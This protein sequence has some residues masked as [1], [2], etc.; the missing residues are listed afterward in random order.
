MNNQV[1]EPDNQESIIARWHCKE[2]REIVSDDRLFVRWRAA[3]T[4]R[5]QADL[6]ANGIFRI[7]SNDRNS[8][9]T[10]G[11][12]LVKPSS[13]LSWIAQSVR[14]ERDRTSDLWRMPLRCSHRSH[15]IS[16]SFRIS[17]DSHHLP[18]QRDLI[19]W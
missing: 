18:V 15:A 16:H 4:R 12:K 11:G 2:E 3:C 17:I 8:G 14:P 10:E 5:S 7:S 1:V 13:N 19:V 9:W 6:D